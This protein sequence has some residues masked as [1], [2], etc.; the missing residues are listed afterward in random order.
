MAGPELFDITEFECICIFRNVEC[1]SNCFSFFKDLVTLAILTSNITIRVT[2]LVLNHSFV[3]NFYSLDN[4]L[5]NLNDCLS[6]YNAAFSS[7]FLRTF[8]SSHLSPFV[9][10]RPVIK[11]RFVIHRGR[12][13]Q[14]F[15]G[16]FCF[17]EW[18]K[19]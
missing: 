1:L 10:T 13:H 16:S 7:S 18:Q 17:Y 15:T 3:F 12:Y 8:F 9:T 6:S 4:E 5:E 14:H 11:C 19:N 2:K